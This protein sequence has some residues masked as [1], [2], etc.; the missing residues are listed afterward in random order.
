MLAV[1][2]L[3]LYA[4][5][6]PELPV[7]N[8][9][10]FLPVIRTQIDRALAEAKAHPRDASTIGAL[11]MTLHA[12]QQHDAAA[13]A[14]SRAHSLD[15]HNFDWIYLLGTVQMQVGAFDA[16]AKSLRS[17]LVIR[18]GELTAELRLAETLILMANW[19][20]AGTRYRSI[21]AAHPECPQAWYG[22]GRVEAAKG[23]HGGAADAYA[24]A[25]HLFPQY[26]AA[27][28]ALAAELRRQGRSADAKEHLARYSQNA[29]AEPPLNDPLFARIHALNQSATVHIQ[30]G[31]ELE[32]AGKLSEAI[33]EHEAA[34]ASDPSN[35]QVHINLI[36]LYGRGGEAD[37][38]KAH[39]D[40]S[41]QQNP[42]RA[43]A[44]YNYG[45]LLA[46]GKNDTEAEQA[47][48][49][50]IEINPNYAE[51]HNN[52][53]A[54]YQQHGRLD[55]AA[56]EFRQAIADQPNYP[57]ARFHLGRILANQ[58]QYAEAIEQFRKALKPADERTPTYLYAIGAT[59]ARAGD[60][61]QARHYLQQA[62]DTASAHGQKE[63]LTSIERDLLALQQ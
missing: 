16:A 59:Y 7:V 10:K 11:A 42:G 1:I 6:L 27:H 44:W 41:L 45:V 53:G 4:G 34:L 61:R 37:K 31:M 29:A 22:L 60:L 13:R 14:Y 38:A 5:T 33:R 3:G 43:D 55:D 26:G 30:R 18:A 12:Y 17:A 25:S 52:L 47:F 51:A 24:K 63:L 35:V 36:S 20:Q 50:A 40:A 58:N 39:F 19:D 62:R 21:L 28:F 46:H 32:R 9:A 8:T 57:L 48:R 2:P 15:P 49:R 56:R 54:I 23:N